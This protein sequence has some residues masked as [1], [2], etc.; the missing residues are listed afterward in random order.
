MIIDLLKELATQISKKSNDGITNKLEDAFHTT[1]SVIYA[2]MAY[3]TK[4]QIFFDKQSMNVINNDEAA[5][6]LK[7]EYRSPYV[8]PFKA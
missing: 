4:S 2:D 5:L 6:L 8:H 3:I 7:R 1:A